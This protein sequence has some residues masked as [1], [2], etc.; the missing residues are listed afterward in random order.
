VAEVQAAAPATAPAGLPPRAAS[1]S[2]SYQGRSTGKPARFE[3]I[4][5]PEGVIEAKVTVQ[6]G[7]QTRSYYLSGDYSLAPDGTATVALVQEGSRTPAV[8]S[9][10]INSDGARGRVTMAS[11]D[12]GRFIGTR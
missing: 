9:G 10:S 3:F 2:G 4:F 1:L 6:V 11:K 8:Y 7:R 5:R 12:V